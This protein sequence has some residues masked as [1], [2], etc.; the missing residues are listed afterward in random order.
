[1]HCSL[2]SRKAV[3]RLFGS[4]SYR[5]LRQ[6]DLCVVGYCLNAGESV[7]RSSFAST[8]AVARAINPALAPCGT[9]EPYIFSRLLSKK[10]PA[11]FGKF[12]PRG[13]TM[14]AAATGE[15]AG[16]ETVGADEKSNDPGSNNE[17]QDPKDSSKD[18]DDN[19]GRFGRLM[20]PYT[21]I[22]LGIGSVLILDLVDSGGLR[23][24]ITMQEFIGKHLLKG[25]VDRIQIV[26]KDFCRC[27]LNS[28]AEQG[29][30]RFVTFRIGSIEAFEQKLDDI[31]ASI[32]L[33]PQDYIPIH[34][35]N[36]V[37][38]IGEL[39]RSI[40]ILM[41][42]ALL[43]IGLRK[44]TMKS[45]GG[46]DRFLRMG[47]INLVDAK[48]VRV[49]VKFKDVAGMHE[50]KREIAEFVDFLKN[51]KSY[52][53][54][55]AKIPKG[56]LLCGAPGTGKTL[57]AKAVAGEANVPFYSISG[58]DFIEVFVGVGPSR[59][60]D[61]FEKA[62]K[63]APSIVFID[64]IDAVGKKRAKG[65]FSGGANDERENTLN[66]ILVEMDGFKPSS[67]V[68]VLAGTNRA[69]ILDPA[70]VRP[71]RFDRTITI[72]K[73]DLEERFEI[74]KV[75]LA[76]LKFDKSL[77]V[78]G[79]ARRLAALTPSFVG[80]EIANV[81]NE[82]AIQAV[83]RKSEDGVCL[84]DFDAAIERIMAGLR[85][86]NS[87]LSPAQKLAVA[88]HE[89]GHALIGWWLE[90]ADPVLKVSIIPRSSGALGFSQQLPDEAMLF[91]R[92][93]LLDKIAVILGG[94][95]AEDIFIG[96]ITTG[97]TD[98]LNKVTKMCY[99]FVSQW[100]MNPELGLVS[101][102]REAGDEPE[103]YR[104]Y[105]EATAQIIDREVRNIIETQY[106]RVKDMLQEKA[107]LVHKLSEMLY[108]R[109]TI[110]YHDIA[111]C[112]GEREF[113]VP[114]KLRPYI[115]SGMVGDAE[116]PKLAVEESARV[117]STDATN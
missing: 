92:E 103:F 115:V 109:E 56:A 47:K 83:R 90:H 67:G 11:G 96:R 49:N 25:H 3:R 54:Y 44:L 105:S 113:P 30:P 108:Q 37:N 6:H 27:S 104:T 4:A 69:D 59:V 94:R 8:S 76:P 89:V 64:E 86:S 80:A 34:Y 28:N 36:E 58:S 71:G 35:V 46:M 1:M 2:S 23:N 117:T 51:P 75:H 93:A 102:Q 79:L 65:G 77:D 41:V 10:V 74:F 68:I 78:D 22:I 26:N 100:G 21:L 70:L 110:T 45:T 101:Y 63:N 17:S 40:P 33:H 114:E 38:V 14:G 52:E 66:Q 62:R 5:F 91:S 84:V 72:N 61:L 82:A 24:E 106:N 18:D 20:E 57:L 43:G 12:T 50:A 42:M 9:S 99:A 88:Y 98:D 16:T 73:P 19:K 95:A 32:G 111:S 112:V 48:D 60:R 97:A 31:Q 81:A 53:K 13:D 55:G 39:K 29:A 116:L 7:S 87:L 15:Q 107:N 85:R